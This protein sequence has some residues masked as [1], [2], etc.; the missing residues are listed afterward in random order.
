MIKYKTHTE[1]ITL[2]KFFATQGQYSVVRIYS[3]YHGNIY[4]KYRSVS[5]LKCDIAK[6]MLKGRVRIVSIETKKSLFINKEESFLGH[7]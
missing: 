1:L 3:T 5:T 4:N 6:L 2:I 7:L